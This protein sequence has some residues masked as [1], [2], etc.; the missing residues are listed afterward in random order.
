MKHL[1]LVF[2]VPFH[3]FVESQPR[4]LIRYCMKMKVLDPWKILSSMKNGFIW[5]EKLAKWTLLNGFY[6]IKLKTKGPS[7]MMSP[8]PLELNLKTPNIK[9]P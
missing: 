6:S 8:H 1:F 9:D 4:M 5:G 7:P 2:K 3:L